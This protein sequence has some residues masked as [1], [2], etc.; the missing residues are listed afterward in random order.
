MELTELSANSLLNGYR[1]RAFSPVEVLD[2]VISRVH[3]LNPK[4]NAFLAI[5]EEGARNEALLAEKAWSAGNPRGLLCGV[6][7]SVK[8]SIEQSG[9]PTTYGSKAFEFNVPPD[10]LVVSRLREHGAVLFGKTNL[11]EFALRPETR[12]Q[13]REPGR[14]PWDLARTCGGSSGGAGSAVS[15]GLGPVA[16]GTD[17]G[18]SI[19]GP[20]VQNGI[21]GL[22]PSFQRI[23]AA[24]HWRASHDRS[25]I[26]PMTRSVLDSALLMEA[27]AGYAPEDPNSF[28]VSDKI[29]VESVLESYGHLRIGFAPC[30]LSGV[31]A[32]DVAQAL[33]DARSLMTLC[34]YS[35]KDVP[36]PPRYVAL[37][38]PD[39]TWPYSGDHLAAAEQLVPNFLEQHFEN[40]TDYAQTVYS[41]GAKLLAVDYR[42]AILHDLN[43]RI[44]MQRWLR[45]QEIDILIMECVSSAPVIGPQGRATDL[46]SNG[47]AM[48][49]I[50][51][52][53][54][55]AIPVR[56]SSNSG[57]PLGLQVVGNFGQDAQTLSICHQFER[58]GLWIHDRP[59]I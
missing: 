43:Y 25:H 23:P 58:N 52:L 16:I 30:Q 8:D 1:R 26:G 37:R 54:V 55:G 45:D 19:R 46:E 33:G 13:L 24:Q 51:R 48:F 36:Y 10:S 29:T 40:L 35:T 5:D 49:N 27:L 2:A 34:G 56:R 44:Q 18:G 57:M 22:K 3:V 39:G 4:L 41:S 17:S 21:F 38:S 50:A 20:S 47:L 12:N 9:M 31:D 32:D 59:T 15:A 7:V 42:R 28:F 11:P 53:P 6:P 14:N